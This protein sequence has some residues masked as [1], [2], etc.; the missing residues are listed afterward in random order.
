MVER[1]LT[2][3]SNAMNKCSL[4]A[5]AVLCSL[6]V[7]ATGRKSLVAAHNDSVIA[8]TRIIHLDGDSP[9][10]SRLD[11]PALTPR[12][13]SLRNMV[14]AFY[15][16]QFRHLQDPETPNFLFLSKNANLMMGIG[17]VVRMRGWY[18]WGGVIPSNGFMPY[19]IPIPQNPASTRRLGTTAA[20]TALFFQ[21]S[22]KSRIGTYR[23]YIEANFNGYMGRG[24]MLKKAYATL[25]DF[26]V[27]YANSTFSDPAAMA[28]TIDAQGATNKLSK[29]DVLVRYMPTF[30]R[31]WTMAV[32]LENPASQI[33]VSDGHT[34]TTSEWLPDFS[35][36][37]Q[38]QWGDGEHVRLSGILRNLGYRDLVEERNHNVTGWA[39]QLS[40]MAHPLPPV[41]TYLTFNYGHGYGGLTNDLLA[42]S[43]DLVPDPAQEGRLYAP[44]SFGY[45][46]GVQYNFTHALFASASFSQTRYL[47]QHPVPP[48]EYRYGWCADLNVFW[49]IL[50]RLQVAAEFNLGRR[51]NQDGTNRYA[52][53]IGAMC[54][55]SF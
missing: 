40:S 30:H 12:Q 3:N 1:T 24:F 51:M 36:F 37:I 9:R 44:R 55:F 29:T 27:G 33:D 13:D 42:G 39:L 41:T 14:A 19:L 32:S 25:G 7:Y 18:E 17:G 49:N 23:L 48:Q 6:P 38:Y 26:T 52:R 47:P 46:I 4:L 31:H 8:T 54:Q 43:Y 15:Y 5:L 16:D 21:M 45:C 11:S 28:P 53:R 10:V 22:G 50:P 2:K 35:A 34:A 20:G